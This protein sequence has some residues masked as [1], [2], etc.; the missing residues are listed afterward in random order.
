[1]ADKVVVHF[2]DGRLVKGF[3]TG[4]T[5][6]T[7]TIRVAD[8]NDPSREVEINLAALKAVFFVK[9]FVGDSS[10]DEVKAFR[11]PPASGERRMVF[12]LHDG[13]VLIGSVNGYQPERDGFFL[14]PADP[15]SNNL[16]CFIVAAAV[17]SASIV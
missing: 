3:T 6:T 4:F 17:H 7:P 15:Q 1:M 14:R 2:R 10:Y 5:G 11:T 8:V 9:D 12:T 16:S 13:E